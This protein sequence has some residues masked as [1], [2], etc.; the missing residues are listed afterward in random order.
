MPGVVFTWADLAQYKNE[1]RFLDGDPPDIKT[2][3][4]GRDDVHGLLRDVLKSA[5]HSIVLNMFGYDD[6]ELDSIIREKL[7]TEHVYVQMSLD[8]TQATGVHE[9][10]ILTKWSNDKLGNSIAIGTSAKHAISHLKLLIVDG[11]YLVTGSTNWSASGE[12]LQDNECTI[13]NNAV[14]AAAARTV[15]DINH[16]FMLK[17]MAAKGAQPAPATPSNGPAQPPQGN[18]P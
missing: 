5:Q 15:L 9:K 16:D 1:K 4:A 3:W 17:Q 14:R 18:T 13:G 8:S 6:D 10:D 7:D 11:V 12:G 2:F